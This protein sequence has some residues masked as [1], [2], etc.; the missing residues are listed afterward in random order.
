MI[1]FGLFQFFSSSYLFGE[2]ETKKSDQ[3]QAENESAL[4][5]KYSEEELEIEKMANRL[6]EEKKELEKLKIKFD[7]VS[8][9]GK[10]RNR[11]EGEAGK[12]FK[13]ESMS[14]AGENIPRDQLISL[15]GHREEE[16]VPDKADRNM[17][18]GENKKEK[19]IIKDKD[20]IV[21][22]FEIAENL[23]K[24]E[25]YQL[26]LDIYKLIKVEEAEE[27]GSWIKYQIAN[28]YRNLKQFD[29]A[30][31]MYKEVD[32][33]FEGSYWAKQSQWYIQD[34][35]WRKEIDGKIKAVVEK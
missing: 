31:E 3:S 22:P 2:F 13:D 1:S 11:S 4:E 7:K 18:V 23:Y 16:K 34:I 21:Q 10:Q 32:K 35:E 27:N 30:V 28:C 6:K 25:E 26:S 20:K 29:K 24:M 19:I 5:E 15:F 12:D 17:V 14:I 33:E 8:K 9:K